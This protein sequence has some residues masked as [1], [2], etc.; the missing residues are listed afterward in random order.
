MSLDVVH[1]VYGYFGLSFLACFSVWCYW[2]WMFF[3][4]RNVGLFDLFKAW[5][6]SVLVIPLVMLVVYS[7]L[8]LVVSLGVV[9]ADFVVDVLTDAG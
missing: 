2:G 3:V 4:R 8:L 9:L 6:V 7:V 5:V 1:L